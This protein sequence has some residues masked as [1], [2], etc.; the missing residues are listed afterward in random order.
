MASRHFTKIFTFTSSSGKAVNFEENSTFNYSP[1]SVTGFCTYETF[2]GNFDMNIN[3]EIKI[4]SIICLSMVEFS[5][6]E[7]EVTPP[8]QGFPL[9]STQSISSPLVGPNPFHGDIFICY[10]LYIFGYIFIC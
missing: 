1:G 3:H 9:E 8:Q 7:L 2:I 4:F 6:I 5:L 10:H